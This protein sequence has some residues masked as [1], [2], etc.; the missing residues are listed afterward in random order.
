MCIGPAPARH[1]PGQNAPFAPL[2]HDLPHYAHICPQCPICP[3]LVGFGVFVVVAG[4]LPGVRTWSVRGVD[5]AYG[6]LVAHDAAV[7]Q[8]A[9][10]SDLSLMSSFTNS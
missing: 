5:G 8:G 3:C 10:M 7:A 2:C 1:T 9:V 6:A 4:G